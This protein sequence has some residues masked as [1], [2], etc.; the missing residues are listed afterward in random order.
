MGQVGLGPLA[1]D[2]P[3]KSLVS[4]GYRGFAETT[5]DTG[6]WKKSRYGCVCE[7]RIQ[8][9]SFAFVDQLWTWWPSHWRDDNF[10]V[11]DGENILAICL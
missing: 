11:L 8:P 2:Y 7:G 4:G 1:Q 10:V 9:I 5:G 3:A 6:F